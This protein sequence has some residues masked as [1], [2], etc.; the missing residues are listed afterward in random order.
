VTELLRRGAPAAIAASYMVP[1]HPAAEFIQLPYHFARDESLTDAMLLTRQALGEDGYHP[2]AWACFVHHGAAELRVDRPHDGT[3]SSWSEW[4]AAHLASGNDAH[5]AAA[6]AAIAADPRLPSEVAREKGGRP[7][8]GKDRRLAR[9][10][11]PSDNNGQDDWEEARM[12][13]VSYRHD[14]GRDWAD[15]IVEH[16]IRPVDGDHVDGHHVDRD[17]VFIDHSDRTSE[18]AGS[19]GWRKRFLRQLCTFPCVL[20]AVIDP[21]WTRALSSRPPRGRDVSFVSQELTWAYRAECPLFPV[22]VPGAVWPTKPK[23]LA[24]GAV[25]MVRGEGNVKPLVELTPQTIEPAL[26]DLA[27]AVEKEMVSQVEAREAARQVGTLTRQEAI[28]GQTI[29]TA[30][31]K[32]RYLLELGLLSQ[33]QL[34]QLQISDENRK[35]NESAADVLRRADDEIPAKLRDSGSRYADGLPAELELDTSWM[36]RKQKRQFSKLA[37]Q[38]FDIDVED[39]PWPLP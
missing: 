4:A 39:K 27:K 18:G 21:G 38:G 22:L 33:A 29:E 36:T 25:E 2:A 23:R 9:Y 30:E 7:L 17:L 19:I 6:R 26:R 1:D 13:F 37:K 5:L 24:A 35:V 31:G 16:L 3:P 11:C 8:R 12:I 15:R 34:N 10:T 14:G 20:I 28:I 32:R